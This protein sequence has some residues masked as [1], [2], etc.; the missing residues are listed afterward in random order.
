MAYGTGL[1]VRGKHY[2][3]A[4]SL[5]DK[6]ELILQ[7][8]EKAI[9]LS[10]GSW[11]FFTPTTSSFQDWNQLYKMKGD[12]LTI[13]LPRNVRI[14]T[15]EPWKDGEVLLRLEHIF[16]EGET[17]LYSTVAQVDLKELFAS[18]SVD[19]VRETTLGA[20]QFLKD[21]QR[22]KWTSGT[23]DNVETGNLDSDKVQVTKQLSVLANLPDTEELQRFREAMG[24]MQHHDAI[25]GTAMKNVAFDYAKLLHRSISKGEHVASKALSNWALKEK[26][27]NA[28]EWWLEY[29]RRGYHK[30]PITD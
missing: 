10:L 11:L 5:M 19:W 14:L 18:F 7:E 8:K 1:V 9:E 23:D 2:L 3:L 4:G 15:L 16:E 6:D 12:G 30:L 24:V 17:S 28:P 26:I 29:E 20:N 25:T 13:S 21:E 22:L 27:S